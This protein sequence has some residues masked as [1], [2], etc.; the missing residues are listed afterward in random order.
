VPRVIL[1]L[2]IAFVVYILF[3]RAQGTP[4]EKRRAEYIKLGLAITVLIVVGLTV[5]GRMHWVGA[6][7]TGL[8]VAARQM[9]PT[10]IR[11]FPML[12]A[13]LGKSPPEGASK[14]SSGP[15]MSAEEALAVLGLEE[16]ASEEE[17]V[18]A[19]RSMMQKNHPDRGGSDYLAAKINQAK[20]TLT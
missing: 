5:T 10:L 2:A 4:P 17:I 12:A 16:G 18:T 20:D 6:A 7:I 19:H 8:L 15:N 14:P 9:M 11:L 3:K 13:R 1:L